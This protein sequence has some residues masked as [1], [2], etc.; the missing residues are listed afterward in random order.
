[1]REAIKQIIENGG[2]IKVPYKREISSWYGEVSI[3]KIE[4][5]YFIQNTKFSDIDE[6][7]SYFLNEAYTSKN[8]GFL[9]DRI[10]K[11][12]LLDGDDVLSIENPTDEL[13]KIF[14]EEGRIVDEEAK[15]FNIKISKFP[16]ESDALDEFIKIVKNF[17]ESTIRNE[18]V[19]F[20]KYS[21]CTYPLK[22]LPY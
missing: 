9:Q 7:V 13:K 22:L 11:K 15:K 8:K 2:T 17:N 4:D 5:F 21:P 20:E 14:E 1:M 16:K 3:Y 12:G 19:Q 10:V 6:A 18:L